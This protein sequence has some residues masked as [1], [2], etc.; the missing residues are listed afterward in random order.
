MTWLWY[1]V[2]SSSGVPQYGVFREENGV[3]IELRD[4]LGNRVSTIRVNGYSFNLNTGDAVN[5]NTGQTINL[6]T[7]PPAYI[8]KS[9]AYPGTLDV[10]I[11]PSISPLINGLT[12][13]KTISIDPQGTGF[14]SPNVT[15]IIKN[16]IAAGSA[17][18]TPSNPPMVPQEIP[19]ANYNPEN[20]L[21][22]SARVAIAGPAAGIFDMG[23]FPKMQNINGPALTAATPRNGLLN[24]MRVD[25]SGYDEAIQACSGLQYSDVKN[26]NKSAGVSSTDTSCGWI[27][28]SQ[29]G[30]GASVLGT[31][32]AVISKMPPGVTATSKYYPPILTT[33]SKSVAD[34]WANAIQCVPSLRSVIC[35]KTTESFINPM[36][37]GTFAG[38]DDAFAT[39]FLE[40]YPMPSTTPVS[41]DK[42]I[43]VDTNAGAMAATLYQDSERGLSDPSMETRSSY[44]MFNKAMTPT[45]QHDR[46]SWEKGFT[47]FQP[48]GNDEY[49]RPSRDISVFAT[50]LDAHDFCAEM[51]E[52]TIINENN[53]A[54]L[55][56]EWLRKGGKPT[57]YNYPDA[58]L[59]GSCYGRVTRK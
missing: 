24:V 9:L 36:V 19:L 59:Y 15:N 52:Q 49:P 30:G 7:V 55:Q 5:V 37:S 18:Q 22:N 28:F 33:S 17:S 1:T 2:N 10:S 54:C 11:H 23:K 20:S 38:V 34:N 58:R 57:D 41:R 32:F 13:G 53:L 50:N 14:N 8:Y 35:S 48:V 51:T 26:M 42:F 40:H 44:S 56:R 6:S 29:G 4:T 46:E 12:I 21:Q 43:K 3:A 27:Q 45:T 16:A 47:P 39:P 31:N 25:R